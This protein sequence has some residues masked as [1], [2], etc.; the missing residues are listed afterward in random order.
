MSRV[1][2]ADCGIELQRSSLRSHRNSQKHLDAANEN[3][4][5]AEEARAASGCSVCGGE[6][7]LLGSLG[8]KTWYRCRACGVDQTV[9]L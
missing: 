2:C 3:E 6:L 1:T 5:R 9:S 4:L 7:Q 8:S